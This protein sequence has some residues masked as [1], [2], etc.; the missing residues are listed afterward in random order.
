MEQVQGEQAGAIRIV[1]V[2]RGHR[3]VI[4][5]YRVTS[6][7]DV[8]AA[9][10]Q[11]DEERIRGAGS[12]GMDVDAYAEAVFDDGTAERVYVPH[13]PVFA[14]LPQGTAREARAFVTEQA[15]A[16]VWNGNNHVGAPYGHTRTMLEAIRGRRHS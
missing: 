4:D 13:D 16:T 1:R 11:A 5:E 8:A 9:L 2:V 15:S 10:D 7:V 3:R 14:A 6:L 12:F